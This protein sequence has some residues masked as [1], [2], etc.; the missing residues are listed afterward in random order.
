MIFV[1]VV[2]REEIPFDPVNTIEK[3]TITETTEIVPEE[4]TVKETASNTP[5]IKNPSNDYEISVNEGFD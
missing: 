5:I 2:K 1:E 4:T 3:E